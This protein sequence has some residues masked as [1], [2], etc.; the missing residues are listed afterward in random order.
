MPLPSDFT[1]G[2]IRIRRLDLADVDALFASVRASLPE[3]MAFMPWAHP[4]YSREETSV[5]LAASY[6][7]WSTGAA[8]EFAILDADSGAH[9][10]GVGINS[11]S[12]A[13]SVANLGYWVRSDAAGRG[14]CTAAARLAAR[15]AF[16]HVGLRRLKLYHAVDNSASGAIARKLGF[17]REGLLRARLSAGGRVHDAVLYGM[18]GLDELR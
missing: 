2:A 6:L 13:E 4:D 8:F 11:Y 7:A 16:E 1:D 3:L 18:I 17:Q 12:R 14:V 9:L 15:F 10:G 5:F